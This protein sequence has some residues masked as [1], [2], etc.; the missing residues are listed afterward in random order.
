MEN[1]NPANLKVVYMDRLSSCEIYFNSVQYRRILQNINLSIHKGEVWGISGNSLLEIKLLLEIM[2]NI[3]PYNDGRCVLIERG[4]M[5]LKRIIL[6]HV[7]YIGTANMIYNS[8]N[9]LEYLMFATAKSKTD[10]V[11]RQKQLLQLLIDI[12][13]SNISLSPI[14]TLPDEYKVIII[15]LVA[16][17]SKS[18][19]IVF[20]IPELKYTSQQV[21]VVKNIANLCIESGKTLVISTTDSNLIEEVCSHIAFL[22]NGN[23]A[24]SGPVRDFCELYDD[25]TIIIYG[26]QLESILNFL[27][28]EMP[29]YN[30]EV[31]N[32]QLII[33]RPAFGYLE[34]IKFIHNKISQ[35]QLTPNQINLSPKTVKNAVKGILKKHDIQG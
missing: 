34:D 9:V 23:V 28:N 5:R 31:I 30:Y 15:L 29:Q 21:S 16:Y 27:K 32:N 13:L 19:L 7:F 11:M 22:I 18:E 35:L 1:S 10:V 8:M 3:K 26:N 6:P 24:Y 20:N 25:T 17:L 14:H 12:G 2:A 33:S 4:M